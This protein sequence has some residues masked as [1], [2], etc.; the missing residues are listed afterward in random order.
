MLNV[1]NIETN[2]FNANVNTCIIYV[3]KGIS[4]YTL[5]YYRGKMSGSLLNLDL[6]S[7]ASK[8]DYLS[9]ENILIQPFG[10]RDESNLIK[11]IASSK[12]T[13]SSYCSVKFGMQLRNRKL[14]TSDV[15]QD[16]SIDEMTKYHR[17]CLTGK[18]VVPYSSNYNNLYCYF[19]RDA[20]CGGCWDE[21]I[22]NAT[23][24]VLVRQV[25]SVP[26]CG[27]DINGYAILNSVFMIVGNTLSP[28]YVMAIIN[29]KLI[30][31]YWHNVFEDRRITF[32][33][34][35]G[36]YLEKIPF[37]R[38]LNNIIEE[39]SKSIY[40]KKQENS[41]TTIEEQEIDE[42]VY[43]LYG[44]TYDEVKIVDPQTPITREEYE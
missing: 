15:L 42:L 7:S 8:E 22:H 36:S 14:Y 11:K 25:G 13:L 1:L 4:E 33:K 30:R 38:P 32:P 27:I 26:I 35:K 39:L 37:T 3:M 16:P 20:K 44:L 18:D 21:T 29:S 34:I 2:V 9:L 31:F 6:L 40:I 23:E 19:N 41:N 5:N 12:E 24:K 28:F 43:K 17:K 10:N